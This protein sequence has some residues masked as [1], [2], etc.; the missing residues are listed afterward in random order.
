[1]R[2]R[3]NQESVELDGG[4]LTV[5]RL[6]E[7]RRI[8][9]KAIVVAVNGEVVPREEWGSRALSEGDEVE[10]VHA[11][12]G[13]S[14]EDELEI[15]GVRF[16]S[17]L[18]LGTGKYEDMETMR[19]AL[20]RSGTEMV[21]VAVRYMDLSGE[22]SILQ[23]LDLSRYR[24]LP[25]TAGATT[26]EQAV[27]MAR[28]AR[29]ATGTNW[30]KL[31]VI[32]DQK[33]LWPDTGATVEATKE[34]VAEDFVVLPYTSTDL[35]A[36]IRLEEAGAA[37]VM[38]LAS[39]IGSGQG[40]PDWASIS[41]IVERITVPV[42]VDAGLGVPSDAAFAMELGA[43]A[44]LVNTAIA[45]AGNPPQMAEAMKLGVRAGRLAYLAGRMPVSR[46]AVPSSPT[47]GVPAASES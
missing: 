38:P 35:V 33:T 40:M 24:L 3:L 4:R 27:K 20:E 2:I 42:V 46:Y 39:P 43:D 9:D 30:V 36:A 16:S 13:G 11:V 44:V 45:R 15:A 14:G 47:R 21:T 41:R 31:E 25:N 12:A 28:L 23:E 29:E 19:E 1:M 5:R 22:R 7:E 8:P 17:R 34:L 37:T 6:L 26:A 32:G 10:I 18:F